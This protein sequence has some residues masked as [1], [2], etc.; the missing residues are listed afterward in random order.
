MCLKT[1]ST[2]NV[3]ESL[4][5][6]DPIDISSLEDL[7]IVPVFNKDEYSLIKPMEEIIQG[8]RAIHT[9]SFYVELD[10]KNRV[11]QNGLG[12]RSQWFTKDE[13]KSILHSNVEPIPIEVTTND[14]THTF[15]NVFVDRY[16]L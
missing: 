9:N 4:K 10:G 1:I 5:G 12:F 16:I 7:S 11:F 2:P 14:T 6:Y 3:P 13:L 15:G 8:G